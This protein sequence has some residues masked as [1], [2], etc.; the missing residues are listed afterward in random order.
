MSHP[1]TSSDEKLQRFDVKSRE[2]RPTPF[3]HPRLKSNLLLSRILG[4]GPAHG[5]RQKCSRSETCQEE[6]GRGEAGPR[7]RVHGEP[8]PP[9]S[10]LLS[11]QG[12]GVFTTRRR[13]RSLRA[14]PSSPRRVAHETGP[15]EKANRPG[16][17]RDVQRFLILKCSNNGDLPTSWERPQGQASEDGVSSSHPVCPQRLSSPPRSNRS[18]KNTGDGCASPQV[19]ARAGLSLGTPRRA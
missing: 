5:L 13:R 4:R 1:V 19:P 9:R 15:R 16:R 10:P 8:G 18:L 11:F 6:N 7:K 14:S 3:A 2:L 17:E 12:F